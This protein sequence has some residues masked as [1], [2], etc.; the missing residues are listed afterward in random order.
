MRGS[1]Y[2]E[3]STPTPCLGTWGQSRARV[4][5]VT[6]DHL[7][8]ST[9]LSCKGA[10]QRKVQSVDA[11]S[12]AEEPARRPWKVPASLFHELQETSP[13]PTSDVQ[14]PRANS[15]GDTAHLL[16]LGLLAERLSVGNFFFFFMTFHC[17]TDSISAGLI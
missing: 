13:N 1:R 14:T 15:R 11:T 16:S 3:R 4:W 10:A 12:D 2:R 6:E 9:S 17:K 8:L 5:G 7:P